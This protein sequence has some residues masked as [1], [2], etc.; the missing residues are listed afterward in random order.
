LPVVY[1]I[2]NHNCVITYHKVLSPSQILQFALI[3]DYDYNSDLSDMY[4][5]DVQ[6]EVLNGETKKPD[7]V[8]LRTASKASQHQISSTVLSGEGFIDI[9][10]NAD[11]FTKNIKLVRLISVVVT[12]YI[13]FF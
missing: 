12:I 1:S 5:L 6:P 3:V 4:E 13:I 9:K 8:G 11:Y 10:Q 2:Q 7:I